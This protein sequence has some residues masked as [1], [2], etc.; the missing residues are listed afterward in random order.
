M[1]FTENIPEVALGAN[2]G[3]IKFMTRYDVHEIGG[4]TVGTRLERYFTM[5]T[6]Q[7]VNDASLK[8]YTTCALATSST[9]DGKHRRLG[10]GNNR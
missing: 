3:A 4:Q 2:I 7:L 5:I 1:V 6:I 10:Q 9:R 8:F